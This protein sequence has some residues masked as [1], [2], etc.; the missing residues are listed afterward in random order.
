M[1]NIPRTKHAYTLSTL[2]LGTRNHLLQKVCRAQ[3]PLCNNITLESNI[4]ELDYI[5]TGTRRVYHTHALAAHDEERTKTTNKQKK[6]K[7][8]RKTDYTSLESQ[9]PIEQYVQQ[10]H[11]SIYKNELKRS[12]I[13]AMITLSSYLE[14]S[15]IH[16]WSHWKIYRNCQAQQNFAIYQFTCFER[17]RHNVRSRIATEDREYAVWRGCRYT[18]APY[19]TDTRMIVIRVR[20]VY[21][22][23][24]GVSFNNIYSLAILLVLKWTVPT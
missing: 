2:F 6:K 7:A 11:T 17:S 18:R 15:T 14:R 16:T 1:Y 12:R 24:C 5:H 4:C 13:T 21:Y 23:L 8:K 22:Y 10:I 3:N 9:H 19:I 20:N